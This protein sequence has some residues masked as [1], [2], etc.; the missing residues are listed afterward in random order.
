MAL[1]IQIAG[2]GLDVSR[3][4]KPGDHPLILG[5]DADCT[6]CL[7]DPQRNVS[8]R[9]LSVWNE[10]DQLHFHVLSVVKGV[11]VPEGEC[12]PGARGVLWPGQTLLL[13][14]YRVT[15]T[16]V[17][18]AGAE[19][20]NDPWAE[21][22][23]E[24]AQLLSTVAVAPPEDDPFGD[25]GFQSTFG[26]GA[27]SMPAQAAAAPQPAPD[28]AAFFAGLGIT[29]ATP[30]AFTQAELETMGR[31]TRVALRGLLQALQ[32]AGGTRQAVRSEDRTVLESAQVNPLRMDTPL[33]SKLWYLFGGYAATAG[34]IAPDRAVNE[35]VDDLLAH[36]EAMGEAARE[37]VQGALREFDPD[38]LKARLLPGGAKLFSSARAWEA[39][40]R[41]YGE[42]RQDMD[43]WVRRLVDRHFAEAYAQAMLRVKRNT[44]ADG[45]G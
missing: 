7:P 5:R 37:A 20:G 14:D 29:G 6:I 3:R 8:R 32:A 35:V 17:A 31:L 42:R 13:S 10:G 18:P 19:D 34:C 21:F 26:P 25:W 16:A 15:A 4:L 22:E 12:P 39:F 27:T 38:A 23:K 2:P 43:G 9:H 33:D 40:A 44:D 1:D 45:Q 24:A 41:D 30:A 36:Q 11:E 28:L